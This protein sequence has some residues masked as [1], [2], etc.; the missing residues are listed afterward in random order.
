MTLSV[1]F[2]VEPEQHSLEPFQKL[3][4]FVPGLKDENAFRREWQG[5]EVHILT[6]RFTGHSPLFADQQI[7]RV[8]ADTPQEAARL[9]RLTIQETFFAW[10]TAQQVA[11]S[12]YEDWRLLNEKRNQFQHFINW[13]Y[14]REIETGQHVNLPTVFDV[15]VRYM[16]KERNHW[17]NRIGRFLRR[18]KAA[19]PAS[20]WIPQEWRQ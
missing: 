13:A 14:S 11:Q 10:W 6:L 8:V 1:D 2:T 17:Q 12:N 5:D 7:L 15:A 4:H 19:K 9:M 3:G 20:E 18:E 16:R